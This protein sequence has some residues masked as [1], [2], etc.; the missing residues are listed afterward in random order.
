MLHQALIL[1]QL[2][3]Y[4]KDNGLDMTNITYIGYGSRQEKYG[5]E[6]D[7]RIEFKILKNE[8]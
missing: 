2:Y 5:D 8:Y 7:R 6:R 1:W 4:L 3:N